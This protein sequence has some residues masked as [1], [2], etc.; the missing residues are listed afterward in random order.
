MELFR[1][2]STPSVASDGGYRG[3]LASTHSAL[4][5]ASACARRLWVADE[6]TAGEWSHGLGLREVPLVQAPSFDPLTL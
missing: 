1:D 3:E 6:P 5:G 4:E 2:G